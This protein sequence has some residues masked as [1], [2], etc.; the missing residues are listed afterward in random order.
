MN[1]SCL[2]PQVYY[3]IPGDRRLHFKLYSDIYYAQD[4]QFMICHSDVT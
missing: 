4:P 1:I 2:Y 3:K